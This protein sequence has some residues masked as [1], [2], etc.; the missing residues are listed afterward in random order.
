MGSDGSTGNARRIG[1]VTATLLVVANMIG[2]GVFTTT[3]FLVRDLESSLA[4]LLGWALGGVLAV[5]GALAY[6]EL[7]AALPRNG[8]EYQ[9]LRRV[10]HPAVGF[11]AGW[12]S[13]VVGFSAPIAAAS[14]GFGKYAGAL[15]PGLEA[16]DAALGLI[17]VL[18]LMHGLHVRAG[19]GVQNLFVAA[20]VVLILVLIG[21]GL[22]LGKPSQAFAGGASPLLDVMMSPAFAV[23]L[24]FISFSYSGWNGAA[25]LAGEVRDP[26]RTLP[27]ALIVGAGVVTLLYLGLNVAFLGSGPVAGLSGKVAVG[28]IASLRLFGPEAGRLFSG[29]IA[30]ALVSTV[31]AMIMT[32]PRVYQAMGDDFRGLSDLSFRTKGGG[33]AVAVALQALVAGFMVVTATFESLLAYIGFTL[34]LSAGMC[35]IGVFVLRLREPDLPRPYRAW[36]HPLTTL[37][38]V[39]LSGWMM[40][41]TLIH[42][43]GAAL[44]GLATIL[45]GLGI[46]LLVGRNKR[47]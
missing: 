36:G 25:Y 9:I 2:T 30:L 46:Y 6:A 41:H 42:K 34:S 22:V 29:A 39:G 11:V 15:V 20:K 47:D 7:T 40:A 33:P 13:L 4:V 1:L 16:A 24:V 43:P 3:G 21:A 12:V 10:L 37:L 28:H 26:S 23:G 17:L 44:A 14:I 35:A 19:A 38:F 5:C 45:S 18:S 31:S 8:G 32:G 27:R